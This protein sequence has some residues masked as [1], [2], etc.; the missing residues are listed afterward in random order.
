M[1]QICHGCGERFFETDGEWDPHVDDYWYCVKCFEGRTPYCKHHPKVIGYQ[2]SLHCKKCYMHL[3]KVW[4][5][6]RKTELLESFLRASIR[7][8]GN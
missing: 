4:T 6:N 8:S 1:K 7:P 3:I 2:G 5:K